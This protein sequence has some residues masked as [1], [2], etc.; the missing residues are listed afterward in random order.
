MFRAGPEMVMYELPG[1]F[2]DVG[3]DLETAAQRE[4]TEETGY[5]AGSIRYLGASHR[6]TYVNATWNYFLATDCV[7][8]QSRDTHEVEEQIEVK[9][10]SADTLLSNARN[11]RMTDKDAVLYAYDELQK[12]K[13][14]VR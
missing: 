5:V 2:V 6:D 13:E 14:I 12:L 11:D 3:E 8:Q 10:I 9:L 1:G 4:F 7:S